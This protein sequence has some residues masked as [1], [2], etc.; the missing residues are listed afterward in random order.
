LKERLKK[1][2]EYPLAFTLSEKGV[3]LISTATKP[4][5]TLVEALAEDDNQED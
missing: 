2:Q 5:L 4:Q 1:C 3:C